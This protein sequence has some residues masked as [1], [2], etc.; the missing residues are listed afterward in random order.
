MIHLNLREIQLITQEPNLIN[1]IKF[2]I[3]IIYLMMTLAKVCYNICQS[4]VFCRRSLL[5]VEMKKKK[6]TITF[7][8]IFNC[9]LY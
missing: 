6:K 2:L 8:S 3:I 7:Y 9:T 4:R 1:I 5:N